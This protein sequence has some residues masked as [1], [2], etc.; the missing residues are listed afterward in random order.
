MLLMVDVSH[1]LEE[2]RFRIDMVNCEPRFC[3]LACSRHYR[4]KGDLRR[5][6]RY[7]CGKEPQFACSLCSYKAKRNSSLQSHMIFK[8]RTVG[9]KKSDSA[10]WTE[11]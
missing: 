2:E 7:E 9:K 1:S 3:C 5:H 6:L 8:H 4:S 10:G 11:K